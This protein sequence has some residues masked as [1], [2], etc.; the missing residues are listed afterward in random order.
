MRLYPANHPHD[1]VG[2]NMPF[3]KDEWIE[4]GKLG[5]QFIR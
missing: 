1:A 2:S 5:S 3:G 4:R